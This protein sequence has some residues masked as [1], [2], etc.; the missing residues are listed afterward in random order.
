MKGT[1]QDA[2]VWMRHS[3]IW[4]TPEGRRFAAAQ[5]RDLPW[6]DSQWSGWQRSEQKW[7][8]ALILDSAIPGILC[9]Q[10]G[11]QDGI[12]TCGFSSWDFEAGR[13]RRLLADFREGD[14][15]KICSPFK[16]CRG[17]GKKALCHRYPGLQAVFSAAEDCGVECGLYGSTAL[18]WVTG[19]PYRHAGSDFDLYVRQQPGGDARAFGCEL[20]RLEGDCGIRFDVELEMDG[21]GVKLKELFAPGRTVLGK[22][23]CDAALFEKEDGI[24][25]KVRLSC[26]G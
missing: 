4:L 5:I 20:A 3:L 18:E 23:L 25:K 15:E 10:P 19:R 16:L 22:G 11:R 9:R 14:V 21:Y 24:Y 13:R 12:W 17:E 1:V 7:Q 2:S 26:L 8:E 6:S